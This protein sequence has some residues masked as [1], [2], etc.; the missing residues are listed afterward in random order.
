MKTTLAKAL[1][2]KNRLVQELNK[3]NTKIQRSNTLSINAKTQ[4]APVPAFKVNMKNLLEEQEKLTQKLIGTKIA[5]SLA[6]KDLAQQTRIFRLSEL[7]SQKDV[8]GLIRTDS[9]AVLNAGYGEGEY[10]TISVSQISEEA[11]EE[12]ENNLQKEIDTLQEDMEKFNWTTEV[13]LPD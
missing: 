9:G 8:I 6:N 11:K 10:W 4:D 2:V 5:I 3:L 7:K 12:M 1:V 13:E